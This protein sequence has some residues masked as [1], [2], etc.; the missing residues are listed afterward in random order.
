MPLIVQEDSGIEEHGQ[1]RE[2]KSLADL[3]PSYSALHVDH[4]ETSRPTSVFAGV[5]DPNFEEADANL[6]EDSPY[7]EVR[8]AVANFDDPDMLVTTVRAWIIGI[9]LAIALSG[10]DI[11]LHLRYPSVIVAD[12]VALLL[13]FILGRV[14]ERWMPAIKIIGFPLNPGPF[15]IKENVLVTVT[16]SVGAP[17]AYATDV[18]AVQKIFYNEEYSFAFQ[19]MLTVSTQLVGLAV[20][21]V[22]FRVLVAPPSMI[23]PNQLVL[24]AVYNTLHSQEYAGAGKLGG[25]SRE[26]YFS[27]IFV[28]AMVWYFIPGYLFQALSFFSWGCWI[29]PSNI[30]VNQLFGY[31]SGLGLSLITFDWNQ[32]T[33]IGSPLVTPWWAQ[34]NMMIGFVFFYWFLTPVL[35]YTNVWESQFLPISS[36]MAFDNTGSPYNLSRILDSNGFLNK[37]AYQD[38][39]PLYLS[40]TF[41]LSYGSQFLGIAAVITHTLLYFWKPIWKNLR[42]SLREQPDIHAKLM[43]VYD[44]VPLWYYFCVFVVTFVF[45]CVCIELWDTGGMTIWA[46]IIALVLGLVFTVPTGMI[47][48]I[49]NREVGLNVLTEFIIGFMMPGRPKP[50]MLFKTYGYMTQAQALRYIGNFKLGHYMKIPPRA[51]FWSQIIAILV[52]STTQLGVQMWMFHNIPNMCEFNQKDGFTCNGAIV[53]GTASIIWG[54]IGPGLQFSKGQVYFVLM[55]FFIIGAAC[56]LILWALTRKYPF[57]KLN[58]LNFPLIFTGTGYIPPASAINYVPWFLIGFLFQFV[59]RRKHFAYWAKYNYVLSAALDAGTAVGLVLVFFCLQYPMDG[60]LGANTIQKWWGNSVYKH[61]A[62]WN[63]TAL[64]HLPP[65]QTFGHS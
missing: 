60:Q 18:I 24:C 62:D 43:S 1:L 15:T 5:F 57:T 40:P 30:I 58:Y 29:A 23:W 33:F 11:F 7:P 12:F 55:F 9:V 34:A 51:L 26:R 54:V 46:L 52:T 31:R 38:Y 21:G 39:S 20:C 37:T 65:G 3:E 6:D 8:A 17:Y 41:A 53:F 36:L 48:A 14:W 25:I 63:M 10:I 19:W 47:Y 35:Y 16:A 45:S 59:V 13:G 49:T 27:F 44:S 22:T 50:M 28:G 2:D 32:I 56:P 4:V 42:T 61:T 64:K